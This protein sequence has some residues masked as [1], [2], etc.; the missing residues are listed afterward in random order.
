MGIVATSAGQLRE[1]LEVTGGTI[2][3]YEAKA[4]LDACAAYVSE[5]HRSDAK[6]TD[7]PWDWPKSKRDLEIFS[8]IQEHEMDKMMGG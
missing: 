5:H 3:P 1:Y 7:A 8:R 2:S 6:S 4:M